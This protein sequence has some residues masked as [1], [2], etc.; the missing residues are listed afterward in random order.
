VALSNDVNQNGRAD[1]GDQLTYT[2]VIQN[3][4]DTVL[5]QV[6]ATDNFGAVAITSATLQPGATTTQNQVH[7][8]TLPEFN[9]GSLVNNVNVT[10]TPTVGTA[11]T[12]A[13]SATTNFTSPNISVL[14]SFTLTTDLNN[15]NRPD[16]GD[17]ITNSYLINNL[18]DTT[19][20][21]ISLQDT[22]VAGSIPVS[23]ST[24]ASGANV[25]V[26]APQVITAADIAAGVLQGTTT[27]TGTPPEGDVV[28][29]AQPFTLNL[30]APGIS[31]T[32]EVTLINDVAGNG[33]FDVGDD[34]QFRYTVT[35]AGGFDLSG[36]TVTDSLPNDVTLGD[37]NGD[38]PGNLAAGDSEVAQFTYRILASD[39]AAGGIFNTAT[40]TGTPAGAADVTDQNVAIIPV[41]NVAVTVTKTSALFNDVDNDGRVDLGDTVRYTFTVQNTGAV[42]LNNVA[43]N[44]NLFG[45]IAMIDDAA[46]D[47]VTVLG[48]GLSQVGTFDRMIT[49]ADVNAGRIDNIAS[50]TAISPAQV[51][52]NDTDAHTLSLRTGNRVEQTIVILDASGAPKTGPLAVGENFQLEFRFEDLN[53]Q[54]ATTATLGAFT[55]LLINSNSVTVNSIAYSTEYPND[56][57]PLNATAVAG[58]TF[59]ADLGATDGTRI[60]PAQNTLVFTLQLTANAIGD[61]SFITSPSDNILFSVGVFGEDGR[62]NDQT[63]HRG[64]DVSIVAAGGE[65]LAYLDVNGNGHITSLDA[66]MV[67]NHLNE[68]GNAEGEFI[69]STNGLDVTGDGYVSALDALTIINYL[70]AQNDESR[71]SAEPTDRDDYFASLGRSSSLSDDERFDDQIGLLF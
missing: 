62:F 65:P 23:P 32:Q 44:D 55:D 51:S 8:V 61:V 34:L 3:T 50:V 30:S 5:T 66:L 18:G 26:T 64:L 43:L 16:A 19:L 14:K 40:A 7:V 42:T 49:Q 53:P 58:G 47:G 29:D 57:Q 41:G 6:A 9:T 70:N 33:V 11:V 56:R 48:A 15:N 4:G 13:A 37:T 38:G 36:V 27:V 68:F 17:T 69:A 39:L 20:T 54:L 60:A 1:S 67:I 10:G 21:S 46:G 22:F 63:L 28:T 12:A 35:N 31:I 24:L 52:V 71:A 25:T 45:N 59:F 2:Y